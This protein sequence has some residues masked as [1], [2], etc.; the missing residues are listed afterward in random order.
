MKCTTNPSVDENI[1]S[2]IQ[3]VCDQI[4]DIKLLTDLKLELMHTFIEK[5]PTKSLCV[6]ESITK[7]ILVSLEVDESKINCI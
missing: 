5:F 4:Q 1:K 3:T 2:E 7:I 6:I